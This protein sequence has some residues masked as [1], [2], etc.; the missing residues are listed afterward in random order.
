VQAA[1]LIQ[2]AK[3]SALERMVGR[4]AL[5]IELL[6]GAFEARASAE[7]RG[8]LRRYRSCSVPISRRCQLWPS[9][10]KVD[11]VTTYA[12]VAAIHSHGRRLR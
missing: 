3:I 4:Q 2:Q 8:Y 9:P 7:K 5:E 6:K 1:D 12:A 11:T 10:G